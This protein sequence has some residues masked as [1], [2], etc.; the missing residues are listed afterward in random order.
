M[1]YA[2][3]ALILGLIPESVSAA[4]LKNPLGPITDPQSL[5]IRI[6]QIFLGLLS[7]I[8][9][10][11]FIYGGFL[12]LTSAGNAERVKKA[13]ATLVWASAGIVVILGSYTILSFVFSL[14]VK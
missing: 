9:L 8:G 3:F 14:L 10:I 11:M 7:L 1:A 2:L 5:A 12:M 4:M 13:K 6:I